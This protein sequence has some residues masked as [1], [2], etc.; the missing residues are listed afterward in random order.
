MTIES[1]KSITIIYATKP[2]LTTATTFQN[3]AEIVGPAAAASDHPRDCI[4]VASAMATSNLSVVKVSTSNGVCDLKGSCPFR[5]VVTNDGPAVFQGDLRVHDGVAENSSKGIPQSAPSKVEAAASA[6]WTCTSADARSIDCKPVEAKRVIPVGGSLSLDVLV[7]PGP[8]WQKNNVLENCAAAF[9]GDGPAG[10]GCAEVKLDPFK[11]KVSKDGD[12]NCRPGTTCTFTLDIFNDEKIVHDDPVTVVDNLVGLESAEIV[13]ISAANDPFPCSPAPTSLP[14]SCTGKMRLDPGEHNKYTMVVK[15]PEIVSEQ[16]WFSNCAAIGG[17]EPTSKGPAATGGTGAAPTETSCHVVST[18]PQCTGGLVKTRSGECACPAGQSWDGAACVAPKQVCPAGTSGT[19][20]DCKSI[21]T[22]GTNTSKQPETP[23]PKPGTGT[24]GAY[25][26]KSGKTCPAGLEYRSGKCRC[27]RGLDYVNGTCRA[28]QKQQAPQT[29]NVCP[30]DRPVGTPPRCCPEGYQYS[31]GSCRP[32][33]QEVQPCPPGTVGRYPICIPMKQKQEERQ[34]PDCPP[35]YR[36]LRR[37][38]KYGAYCEEIQQAPA[39][40]PAD[41]PNGTPPNCCPPGTRFT[42]GSCYPTQCSPGWTGSPPHCQPPAPAPQPQ[43]T[44][45]TPRQ[46]CPSYMEG[47]YP[48][49]HC[50]SGTTGD[51]CDEVIVR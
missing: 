6:D 13:S 15:L 48:N 22:G 14:F 12:Q 50:P 26:S 8:L 17:P 47:T 2:N 27:P 9:G 34:R 10:F 37:P 42:E 19:Y 39:T 30:P 33:Q 45:P 4:S 5:I 24:G 46:V 7:T 3:C 23:A 38:N 21:G 43:P 41:R 44:G 11:V 16:G 32:L 25:P 40:C 31:R 49:C 36:Q 18:E 29:P 1:G 35:G 20:P 28:P 51:R